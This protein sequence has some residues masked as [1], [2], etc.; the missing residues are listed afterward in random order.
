MPRYFFT[1]LALFVF[2]FAYT[3][4]EYPLFAQHVSPETYLEQYREL[5][6]IK[7]GATLD[8]S[9]Q[10]SELF[11]VP[12]VSHYIQFANHARTLRV[13]LAP[14]KGGVTTIYIEQA[15]PH[16]FFTITGAFLTLPET[17]SFIWTG[18]TTLAFYATNPDEVF[19]RY[20][21]NL[22]TLTLERTPTAH[23]PEAADHESV[24][25]SD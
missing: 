23:A 22:H 13:F 24:L 7:V 16:K 8:G 18:P 21:L 9:I 25:T 1:I 15:R 14:N 6:T 19:M 17:V 20:E 2:L 3:Y 10:I 4:E 5:H 11:D 12:H